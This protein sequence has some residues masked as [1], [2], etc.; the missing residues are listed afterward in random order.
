MIS[1]V[2]VSA[3]LANSFA[4]QFLSRGGVN[5]EFALDKRTADEVRTPE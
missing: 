3:V 1:W 2:S 5:T 4:G